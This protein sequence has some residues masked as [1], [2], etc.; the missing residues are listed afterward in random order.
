MKSI[1]TAVIVFLTV[2][3]YAQKTIDFPSKDGLTITA[4]MYEAKKSS[5]FIILFHQAG[6]SRGEYLEIAPKLNSLGYH[7]MAVDQ[8]SGGAVN[9]VENKTKALAKKEGK[10][11]EFVDAFQDIEAAVDY[12][13]KTYDP[14]KI[15]IWGSSYSSALVLKYAGDNP[16]AVNGVLSFAPGE[17]FGKKNFITSSAANI[18]VPV[19]ITSAKNEKKNWSGIYE[20]I[21][22]GKKQFFLPETKG[23]HGSR[24]LWDKF[25]DSESY[26]NEVKG[27]LKTI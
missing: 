11:T 8:R 27:F 16:D 19:F 6:W 1:L 23:N 22:S 15:I 9:G 20:A 7:C 3:L 12:V 18:K 24:A 26:W 4:D 13:K 5:Q 14:E 21:P 2:S 25:S 17:Y 10:Q